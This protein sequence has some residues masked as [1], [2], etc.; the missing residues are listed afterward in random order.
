VH[1]GPRINQ[2]LHP[3]LLHQLVKA[4]LQAV[5]ANGAEEGEGDKGDKGWVCNAD[6]G[7]HAGELSGRLEGLPPPARQA[8]RRCA[9]HAG[10]APTLLSA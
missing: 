9:P 3:M 2:N 8:L 4:A 7:S 6:G 5:G 1:E 10:A